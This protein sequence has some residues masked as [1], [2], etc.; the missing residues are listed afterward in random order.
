VRDPLKGW[1]RKHTALADPFSIQDAAVA[2]TGFALQL[3]EVG[4]PGVAA[5]VAGGVSETFSATPTG[6]RSSLLTC[7][8]AVG[9][10][11]WM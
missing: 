10:L 6:P 7:A 4:Q 3:V 2:C 9:L 1:T 8:P 5:Q 11:R